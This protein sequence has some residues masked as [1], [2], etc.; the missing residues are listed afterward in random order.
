MEH[1]LET[2]YREKETLLQHGFGSAEEAVGRLE[3]QERQIDILQRENHSYERRLKQLEAEL[4]TDDIPSLVKRVRALE[5]AADTRLDALDPGA[6]ATDASTDYSVHLEAAAPL[7]SPDTLDRLDA[8][9]EEELEALEVG[10]LR[11]DD[12]GVVETFNEAARQLPG[13]GSAAPEDIEGHNFFRDL[14]P[15][16]DNNL[17]RG[18]VKRG[19]R[20]GELDARF[21]YTITG[22]NQNSA[23]FEVHLYRS[24]GSDGTWLLFRP[25]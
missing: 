15:S 16:T 11:L 25:L 8:L 6:A 24:A 22:P 4:G 2:L 19:R 23:S 9:S 10:A 17:F 21:P 5:S 3:T 13:L 14:A 20:R 12:D 7:V 18:R 1:Q